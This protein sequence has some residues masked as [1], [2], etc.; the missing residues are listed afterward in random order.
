MS[1]ANTALPDDF[2]EKILQHA[3]ASK[4]T[5]RDAVEEAILAVLHRPLT[6]EEKWA[7]IDRTDASGSAARLARSVMKRVPGGDK[8]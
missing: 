7:I 4:H 6:S 1:I 3:D 8:Q 5:L 2:V